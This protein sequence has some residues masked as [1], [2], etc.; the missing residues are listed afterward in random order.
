MV[1][2]KIM[3]LT[4]TVPVAQGNSGGPSF[5][6]DGEQIG[7]NTYSYF[8]CADFSK[9]FGNGVVRDIA[10]TKALIEKIR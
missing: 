2:I 10:D 1:Q 9:C 6:S 5:N 3:I 7:L 4:T 8:S